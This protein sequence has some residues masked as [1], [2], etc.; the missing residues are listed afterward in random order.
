MG[1]LGNLFG[2]SK[3]MSSKNLEALI[4][5]GAK[6]ITLD[7]DVKFNKKSSEGIIISRDNIVIDGKGHTIDVNGKGIAF[8]LTGKNITVKNLKFINCL[9]N[10]CGAIYVHSSYECTIENCT[11][12]QC[13]AD[14]GGVILNFGKTTVIGCK[15]QNCQLTALSNQPDGKLKVVKTEVSK[16]RSENAA[17][18]WNFGDCTV[19]DCTFQENGSELGGAIFNGGTLSINN[20]KI[21]K[22]TSDADGGAIGN[23]R[24]SI[25]IKNSSISQN[26][27][28]NG[29]GAIRNQPEGKMTF[30]ECEISKNYSETGGAI[31]NFGEIGVENSKIVENH[32]GHSGAFSLQDGS[33][34]TIRNSELSKNKADN[35]GAVA[36]FGKIVLEDS[37][38]SDNS[39]KEYG[40]AL[41]NTHKGTII[42]HD[43]QFTDNSAGIYGGAILNNDGGVLE[44]TNSK[45]TNNSAHGDDV[46]EGEESVYIVT[47]EDAKIENCDI[48][49]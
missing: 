45:F 2:N 44:I 29:G 16:I 30:V 38:I 34:I 36:A 35:A 23:T 39:A 49:R 1:F 9:G 25:T 37:L 33:V 10:D 22:N 5:G 11:F 19:E 41:L 15:I 27:A 28:K 43:C 21:I 12:E 18:I 26:N 31:V 8:T 3:S 4:N 14:K 13:T 6:Q 7:D 24:G 32:A 42:I 17:G 20:T 47:K 46:A 48:D 40:G